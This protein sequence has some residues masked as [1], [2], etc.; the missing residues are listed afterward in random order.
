MK[1]LL[2]SIF[3]FSLVG[4]LLSGCNLSK[5]AVISDTVKAVITTTPD[6]YEF[7]VPTIGEGT[8]KDYKA[9]ISDNWENKDLKL[10]LI[11]SHYKGDEGLFILKPANSGFIDNSLTP[12]DSGPGEITI[13][14]GDLRI[15]SAVRR[16]N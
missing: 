16:G 15:S 3:L 6:F 5:T 12:S 11:P 1:T 4:V 2:K 7:Y 14:V 10:T 8:L 9:T 13:T